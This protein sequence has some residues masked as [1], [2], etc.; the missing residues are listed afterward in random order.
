[1]LIRSFSLTIL[2]YSCE[3]FYCTYIFCYVLMR[4]YINYFRSVIQ[5]QEYVLWI[6]RKLDT[7]T[8]HRLVE[9]EQCRHRPLR[10]YVLSG[11]MF[12]GL[13]FLQRESKLFDR[14]EEAT[15]NAFRNHCMVSLMRLS[16]PKLSR[17]NNSPV[18][19]LCQFL[20]VYQ[21][22]TI[23]QAFSLIDILLF[24]STICLN[25]SFSLN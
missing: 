23:S 7:Q 3:I 2:P 1:M 4:D 9:N 17:P 19:L 24:Q 20:R 11:T 13:S 5:V 10:N 18:F 6:Y 25:S 12:T 8:V 15:Y 22:F 14:S 21:F 16:Y